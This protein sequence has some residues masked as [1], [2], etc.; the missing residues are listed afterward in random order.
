MARGGTHHDTDTRRLA[1]PQ[2]V[3][4]T[5]ASQ[6]EISNHFSDTKATGMRCR[7]EEAGLRAAGSG[8]ARPPG[9]TAGGARPLPGPA[10]PDTGSRPPPAQG[11]GAQP[12]PTGLGQEGTLALPVAG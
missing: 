10:S 2:E 11:G 8:L 6:Q 3:K 5:S 12:G 4:K 9:P 7:S 1:C